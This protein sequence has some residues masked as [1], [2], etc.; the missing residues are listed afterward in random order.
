MGNTSGATEMFETVI[1]HCSVLSTRCSQKNIP[2][3]PYFV[4]GVWDRQVVIKIEFNP[5]GTGS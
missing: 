3:D 5:K 1:E 4:L 2:P